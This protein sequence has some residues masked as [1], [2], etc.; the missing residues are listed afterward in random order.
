MDNYQE[1]RDKLKETNQS[2][3]YVNLGFY[4][5]DRISQLAVKTLHLCQK[6]YNLLPELLS[7]TSDRT[8]IKQNKQLNQG[9][10]TLRGDMGTLLNETKA[11]LK[12]TKYGD[13]DVE[14]LIKTL[15]EFTST[16]IQNIQVKQFC[17]TIFEYH[18][19][20]VES[21]ILPITAGYS[22]ETGLSRIMRE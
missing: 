1:M 19:K 8:N 17:L 13:A 18:D 4:N 10:I 3:Y 16:P 12:K 11:Q 9:I 22:Q 21:G 5:N 7:K 6:I 14:R 15:K 20:L 2:Q